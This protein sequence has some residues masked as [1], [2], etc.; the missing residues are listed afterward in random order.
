MSGSDENAGAE[1]TSKV[2]GV[3]ST[4]G[5]A[6]GILG[7]GGLLGF[8]SGIAAK[9]AGKVAA[10][11][12]GLIFAIFQ[13]AAYFGYVTINWKKVESDFTKLVD[14]NKDGK[15]DEKDLQKAMDSV[16]EV[17]SKNVPSGSAGFATGFYLGFKKG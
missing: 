14:V 7:L 6:S 11:A 5:P 8:C 1:S 16:N 17:L 4:L 12:I 3:I 10:V 13:V 15:A 2:S 9:K